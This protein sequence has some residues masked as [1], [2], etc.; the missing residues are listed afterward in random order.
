MGKEE[1]DAVLGGAPPSPEDLARLPL[2]DGVVNESMRLLPAIVHLLFK[3]PDAPIQ[4]GEH[5]LP[6]GA[7]IIL[8]PLITHRDPAVFPDPLGFDPLRWQGPAPGPYAW[9][10]F[11]AGPRTCVGASLSS[12]IL[13]VQ[14]AMILQR[15]RPELVAGTRVDL[16]VRAANLLFRGPVPVRLRP[17]AGARAG[18]ERLDGDV[19][20]LVRLG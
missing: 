7:T 17:W 10:P 1:L 5:R 8:S 9:M 16:M 3:R 6:A 15:V 13:R 19:R 12:Y 11:G 4:L 2:L 20:R 18:V 14:L